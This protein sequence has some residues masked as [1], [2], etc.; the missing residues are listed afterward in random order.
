MAA[1]EPNAS[2]DPQDLIIAPV[3][4]RPLE[5]LPPAI[6]EALRD[7]PDLRERVIAIRD[8]FLKL[9]EK[10]RE[11]LSPNLDDIALGC[12]DPGG[13][14]NEWLELLARGEVPTELGHLTLLQAKGKYLEYRFYYEV[15]GRI[16]GDVESALS[17]GLPTAGLVVTHKDLSHLAKLREEGQEAEADAHE[18]RLVERTLEAAA[19]LSRAFFHWVRAFERVLPNLAAVNPADLVRGGVTQAHPRKAG[20]SAKYARGIQDAVSHVYRDGMTEQ[21]CWEALGE[22]EDQT[23]TVEGAEYGFRLDWLGAEIVT[24]WQTED[25]TGHERSVRRASFHPYFAR[26]RDTLKTASPSVRPENL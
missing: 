1:D 19:S 20:S 21:Q 16:R 25:R 13:R 7:F 8:R 14:L 18:V 4:E 26:A 24:A 3:T 2:T 10:G 9:Q 6:T 11:A 5:D 22:V 17:I 23:F 12:P 15:L